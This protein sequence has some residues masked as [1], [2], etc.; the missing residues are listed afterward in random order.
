MQ[1][2]QIKVLSSDVERLLQQS[3][4]Y[5]N[6]IYPPESVNQD[7]TQS[8]LSDSMYLIGAYRDQELLGIGGVKVID[9]EPAYGEIKN[10]FVPIE[11]RGLGAAKIIMSN[12]ESHLSD[13][14]VRLCRLETGLSQPESVGLY[15]RLGYRECSLYG[16]YKPDPLSLFME[17]ELTT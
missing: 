9:S 15:Q 14:G 8:L 7:D 12:L 13:C 4:D 17:K 1:I 3:R 11:H 5:Q 16:A 10:L 6:E 2:K